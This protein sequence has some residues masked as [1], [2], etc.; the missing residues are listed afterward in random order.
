MNVH[1]ARPLTDVIVFTL[2]SA[3]L[4]VGDAVRPSAATATA[5]YVVVYSL[6]GGSIDGTLGAPNDDASVMYQ[7]TSVGADRRQCEWV[8][9]RARQVIL[10]AVMPLTDRIISPVMVDM[11][12]GTIR[13]D[14]I[15]PPV[16]YSPDRYR[17]MTT[18]LVSV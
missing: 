17:V 5:G 16:W 10:S 3:G 18:P 9:D 13:D 4:V 7:L 11:L 12:G 2:Q 14:D 15:Q 8:A 1:A 6:P